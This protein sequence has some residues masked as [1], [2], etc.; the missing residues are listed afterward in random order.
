M[1]QKNL[2]LALGSIRVRIRSR[3]PQ[4]KV[5]FNVDLSALLEIAEVSVGGWV[6][7]EDVMPCRRTRG[8]RYNEEHKY[9]DMYK[10]W[11]TNALPSGLGGGG[12][13]LVVATEYLVKTTIST[14]VYF[15][16]ADIRTR[17]IPY[18]FS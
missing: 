9:N 16:K 3:F 12:G 6:K 17:R 13:K 14:C 15:L 11:K 8:T 5:S 2:S 7:R 4:L 18:R 10:A 1:S